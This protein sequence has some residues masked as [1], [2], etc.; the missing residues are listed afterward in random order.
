MKALDPKA[1]S[2]R[3][4]FWARRRALLFKTLLL[5]ILVVWPLLYSNGYTMRIMTT[6]GLFT[7]LTVAVVVILGQAGQLSFAH[8]AFYGIGAY[9]AALL[10]MKASV[11]TFAALIIGALVAGVIALVVGRPVLKLRYFYLALATIGLGQIFLVLVIQLRTVTGSTM[12]LAP[13]PYLKIFGFTFGTNLRQYYLIWVIAVLVILFVDRAL[14]YRMGRALRGI[15]TSE[16]ASS[17]LGVRTANWKL[18]AFVTSAV[19]CG[20][21]GGLFAFITL[22]LTPSSFAFSTALLPIVMMMLGG[23]S[24]WGA[25]VGAI[26]MT[27]V[28]N[29]FTSI[30]QYT[31]VVY[32]IIMVLLL[33]FLP[34]GLALRPDQR[35]RLKALFRREKLQEVALA[36]VSSAIGAPEGQPAPATSQTQDRGGAGSPGEILLQVE[37]LSVHFGGLKA[38]DQV[39]LQ[40]TAGGI[41]ATHRP[42]RGRQ[43]DLLQRHHPTSEA[44][45]GYCSVRR[46]GCH[47]PLDGGHRPPRYGPHLPEPAHLPQY[48]RARECPRRVPSARALRTLGRRIWSAAPAERREAVAGAGHAGPRFCRAGVAGASVRGESTLRL[49]TSGGDRPSP[50]V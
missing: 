44:D 47:S 32:S 9:T 37:D 17:T 36:G 13:I 28:V 29:G 22:A 20:L 31:G 35:A 23:G 7:M 26:I 50:G 30:E 8:S 34:A 11:P 1:S 24:V 27:W 38:V 41:V 15:A 48:D 25:V 19:I 33:I 46:Q 3:S 42:E 39:S 6:G 21:A 16:I 14:K 2:T 10:A 4:S 43:D 12:G 45:H 49:P 40:V 5:V 18:L